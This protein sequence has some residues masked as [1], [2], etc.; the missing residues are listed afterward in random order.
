M[1]RRQPPPAT[2]GIYVI[3]VA[4]AICG[5]HPQTLRS[6]ERLGFVRPART[7]G[8]ARL[9]SQVDIDVLLRVVALSAEGIPLTGIRRI[10]DLE[11]EVVRLR[12]ELDRAS[13]D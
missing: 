4:A 3:S 10:L 8:G 5:S 7:G 2:D 11:A 13:Q 6:Y 9:Y 1:S 12:A